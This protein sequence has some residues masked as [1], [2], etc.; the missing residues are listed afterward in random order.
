MRR[1]VKR[2]YPSTDWI[3][4]ERKQVLFW[5]RYYHLEHQKTKRRN[6]NNKHHM[7]GYIKI[8]I[9]IIIIVIIIIIIIFNIITI[10]SVSYRGGT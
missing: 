4:L 1:K 2:E 7:G 6:S 3:E 10:G 8:I 9:I 5:M